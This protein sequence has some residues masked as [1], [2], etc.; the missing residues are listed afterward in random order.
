MQTLSDS[1]DLE[2]QLNTQLFIKTLAESG[3]P[4]LN[5]LS[6]KYKST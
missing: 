1:G 5:F 2:L 3:L 4:L 6:L